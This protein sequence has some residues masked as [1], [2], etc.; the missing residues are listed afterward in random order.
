MLNLGDENEAKRY[1]EE[2][3]RLEA[4]EESGQAEPLLF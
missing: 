2:R 1:Q 3:E 4:L